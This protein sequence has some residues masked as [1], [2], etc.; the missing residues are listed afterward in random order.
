M[1]LI[2]LTTPVMV[3]LIFGLEPPT[4]SKITSF[5]GL[6]PGLEIQFPEGWSGIKMNNASLN[7]ATPTGISNNTLPNPA[8]PLDMASMFILAG[9]LLKYD[10]FHLNGSGVSTFLDSVKKNPEMANCIITSSSPVK[11][12]T[13]FGEKVVLQCDNAQKKDIIYGFA[14]EGKNV[15]QINFAGSSVDTLSFIENR[16][17]NSKNKDSKSNRY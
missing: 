12:N 10:P 17:V 3:Q 7:M 14:S 5:T 2:T 16:A 4:V 13:I 9:D 11:I 6:I 15:I 8:G 1:G